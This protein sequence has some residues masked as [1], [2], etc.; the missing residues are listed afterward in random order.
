MAV[1]RVFRSVIDPSTLDIRYSNR[2]RE[3]TIPS[4]PE[5]IVTDSHIISHKVIQDMM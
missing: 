1:F 2:R 4:T 3:V 5:V